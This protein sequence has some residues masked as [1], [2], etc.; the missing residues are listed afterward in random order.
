MLWGVYLNEI[1]DLEKELFDITV[2]QREYAV[3]IDKLELKVEEMNKSLLEI[4]ISQQKNSDKFESLEEKIE[5]YNTVLNE[6]DGEL[7][8]LIQ[9]MKCSF[10]YELNLKFAEHRQEHLRDIE[11]LFDRLNAV[12]DSRSEADIGIQEK[13]TELRFKLEAM[14]ERIDGLNNKK[15]ELRLALLY[16]IIAALATVVMNFIFMAFQ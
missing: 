9:K 10:N 12:R 11:E 16:P 13:F 15:K 3:R 2:N 1:K 8:E 5:K 6:S 4:S 7:K 14:Y